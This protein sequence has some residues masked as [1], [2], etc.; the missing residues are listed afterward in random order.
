MIDAK[1]LQARH[2]KLRESASEYQGA[3][4]KQLFYRVPCK[5]VSHKIERTGYD[6][7]R[8]DIWIKAPDG[9][10]LY[11][12]STFG[13]RTEVDHQKTLD[14]ALKVW[15]ENESAIEAVIKTSS[16]GIIAHA[17]QGGDYAFVKPEGEIRVG[18]CA[19]LQKDKLLNCV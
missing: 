5:V 12:T 6:N 4:K 13:I 10:Q 18:L 14:E 16:R 1:R 7:I 8:F 2:A 3:L 9:K 17:L 15:Q 19:L 11:L